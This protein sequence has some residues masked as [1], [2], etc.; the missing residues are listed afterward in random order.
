MDDT[1]RSPGVFSVVYAP[2]DNAYR[3]VYSLAALMGL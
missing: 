2:V 1:V 3:Y